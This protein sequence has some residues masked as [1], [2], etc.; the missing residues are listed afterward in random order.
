MIQGREPYLGDFI[1]RKSSI[2]FYSDIYKP[3]SFKLGVMVEITEL[4]GWPWATACVQ[5]LVL[6]FQ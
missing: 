3:I 4:F 6:V 5:F 1:E 2:D